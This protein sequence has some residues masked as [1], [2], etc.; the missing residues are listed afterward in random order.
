M[1]ESRLWVHIHYI[2]ALPGHITH[3]DICTIN[4][5]HA[6]FSSLVF[7]FYKSISGVSVHQ[8][9]MFQI[10]ISICQATYNT[11]NYVNIDTIHRKG[12]QSVTQRHIHYIVINLLQHKTLFISRN[13]INHPRYIAVY[14]QNLYTGI[15]FISSAF[16]HS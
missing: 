12:E 10:S 2:D 5:A 4:E 16:R 3:N 9:V 14:N 7:T 6:Q 1:L 13:P 11:K 15:V 8:F